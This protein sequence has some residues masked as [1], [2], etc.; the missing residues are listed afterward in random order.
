MRSVILLDFNGE[1]NLRQ[2]TEAAGTV[3]SK[4]IFLLVSGI[5]ARIPNITPGVSD[6]KNS[7][8]I[9]E[10][11]TYKNFVPNETNH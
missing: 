11:V 5:G 2:M 1:M 6:A 8:I 9:F 3:S 10:S 7:Q 4:S